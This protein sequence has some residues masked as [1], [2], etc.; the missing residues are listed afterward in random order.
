MFRPGEVTLWSGATGSGKSQIIS[1]CV[2]RWIREGSR[3]CI[4]SFEMQRQWTLKR[5]VKQAGG[6]DRP[7]L[8]FLDATLAFLDSR[9]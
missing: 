7:A 1:D 9:P 2:P 8:L 3:I 4:A 6:V 5:M